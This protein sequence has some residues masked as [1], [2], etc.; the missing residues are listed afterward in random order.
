VIKLLESINRVSGDTELTKLLEA[1][2]KSRLK[3][4]CLWLRPVSG[5]IH[6]LPRTN[7]RT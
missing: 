4:G 6:K 7:L 5:A 1:P 3:L 2:T